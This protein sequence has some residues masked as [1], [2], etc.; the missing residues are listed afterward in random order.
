[1]ALTQFL[2]FLHF[3]DEY[4]VMGLAAYGEPTFAAQVGQVV[5][6]TPDGTFRLDLRYFRHLSEGVE[7]SWEDGAPTQ[8]IVFTPALEEL[9]GP[10]RRPDEELTQR[11]KDLA[12][13][14]QR[15][16]EERFFALVRALQER[17]GLR[18]LVLAGGC[19]LNSVANGK[20]FEATDVEEVYIQSAAGDAGTSLGAALYVH[21]A[22]HGAPRDFVMEHSY[23]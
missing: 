22:I 17:T 3:G 20:L 19:A 5:P 23:W 8:G 21:H 12:A 2:G 1:T 14:L 7:M 6:G 10:R 15:V 4:K 9:L 13:S 11:H 16:Y 18:R